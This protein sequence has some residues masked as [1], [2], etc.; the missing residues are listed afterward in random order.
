[1]GPL[2]LTLLLLAG[3]MLAA[4]E[5]HGPV[6]HAMGP[7][8]W[9]DPQPLQTLSAKERIGSPFTKALADGYQ[10]LAQEQAA[11]G[12]DTRHWARKGL[13][14]AEGAVVPPDLPETWDLRGA[15]PPPLRSD[16]GTYQ[17]LYEVRE[18][19]VETF[20]QC[21]TREKDPRTS[22]VAQLSFDG[23]LGA[24][25]GSP[26]S[27]TLQRFSS[28]LESALATLKGLCP[29][30]TDTAFVVLF[31]PGSD[32]LSPESLAVIAGAARAARSGKAISLNG[33]SD[34]VG[35]ELHNIVLAAQRVRAVKMA[36]LHAG[37]SPA[38]IAETALGNS[39]LPV[40]TGPHVAHPENRAV[41]ISV[42]P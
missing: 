19:L 18:D 41:R 9:N 5:T 33:W 11:A 12:L 23:L 20:Y 28:G 1:M 39:R 31:P 14:A 10:S 6:G 34:T 17:D 13:L 40:A 7:F 37:I 22:A 24:L 27:P 15:L 32:R 8:D 36:L 25:D 38:Q 42:D 21:G 4:C 30:T 2:R 16:G 35:A 26:V 3:T 29:S